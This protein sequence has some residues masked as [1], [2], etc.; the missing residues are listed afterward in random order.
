MNPPEYLQAIIVFTGGGLSGS[1]LIPV[2]LAMYWPRFNASGALAGMA[3]GFITHSAS[4]TAGWFAYGEFRPMKIAGF[5]PF[6]PQL[7]VSLLAAVWAS[8]ATAPPDQSLVTRY[9]ARQRTDSV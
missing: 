5:D 3:A 1:F 2:A 6:I 7:I 8:N 9:F 4:Y